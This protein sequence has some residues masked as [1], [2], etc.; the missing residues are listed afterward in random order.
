MLCGLRATFATL[1]PLLL[2]Y[3]TLLPCYLATFATLLPYYPTT[4][5][6]STLLLPGADRQLVS[7]CGVSK[8]TSYRVGDDGA[9]LD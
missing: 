8:P 6:L 2:I 3:S 5:Y 9:N 4:Y 7:D 1:L